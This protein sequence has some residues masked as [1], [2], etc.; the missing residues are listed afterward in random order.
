M[1]KILFSPSEGKFT[2][3]LRT[4]EELLGSTDARYEILKKYNDIVLGDDTK[5][6]SE[7]VGLK[8]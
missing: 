3:G 6:M 5:A 1:L 7:L 4:S 2:G 8:K